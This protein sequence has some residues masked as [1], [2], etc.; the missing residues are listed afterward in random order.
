MER[1]QGYYAVPM[2]FA[3]NRAGGNCASVARESVDDRGGRTKNL[4]RETVQLT[5]RNQR[6][7]CHPNKNH[8]F[9]LPILQNSQNK[10]TSPR[11]GY[12]PPGASASPKH[13]SPPPFTSS[14]SLSSVFPSARAVCLSVDPTHPVD[15]HRRHMRLDRPRL[16]PFI[17][18]M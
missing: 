17:L 7:A 3:P 14:S 1:H 9:R 2:L 15:R 13:S 16:Y 18:R 8:C 11:R 5:E 10:P 6:P 4:K 12:S